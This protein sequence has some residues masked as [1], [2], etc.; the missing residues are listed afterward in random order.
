VDDYKRDED[1]LADFLEDNVAETCGG[2][3]EHADLFKAYQ[4]HCEDSGNRFPMTAR[5]LAKALR[6][7][8]WRDTRTSSSKCVWMGYRLTGAEPF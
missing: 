4:R 7:R 2:T 3:V 6:E 8:G 5:T 1:R